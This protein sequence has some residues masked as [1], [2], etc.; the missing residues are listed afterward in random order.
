MAARSFQPQLQNLVRSHGTTDLIW[1]NTLDSF[2]QVLFFAF[3]F[4]SARF[5]MDGDGDFDPEDVQ[6]S[7]AVSIAEHMIDHVQWSGLR[8]FTAQ[9]F[10]VGVSNPRIMAYPNLKTSFEFLGPLFQIEPL[11]TD[12]TESCPFL[13]YLAAFYCYFI[14]YTQFA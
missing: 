11:K 1:K 13:E 12:R 7:D 3:W 4:G 5:D 2:P 6:A 8:R 14:D 9:H 10:K